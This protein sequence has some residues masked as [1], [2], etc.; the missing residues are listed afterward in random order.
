M[1]QLPDAP[2]LSAPDDRVMTATEPSES[3][4]IPIEAAEAYEAAFVPAFFAQWAPMLC[5]AAHIA[6]GHRIL[7][8]ACGTGIVART[9]ADR[10][11]TEGVV[12]VDLNEAM[13]TV[14]RRV[15]PQ[16]DWRQGDVAALP[17][18]DATF[19]AVLSQMALMFFPDRVGALREMSRVAASG[20][21]V[22]VLVPSSLSAQPAYGPFVDMAVAHAGPEARSLLSMYFACGDIDDL[23]ASFQRA[24]LEVESTA[25]R[26]GTARFPSVDALV[27]TE[28]ESTPLGERISAEVYDRI[29]EGAREVLDPFIMSGGTLE[30]P[31]E[32]NV[33]AA[34]RPSR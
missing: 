19:D 26:G 27:A 1:G 25:T 21:T 22:A 7:D 11:G 30:A 32:V 33:V 20:A 8:V 3:F 18:D 29:R 4:Q 28:V 17:F 23:T 6:A 15:R 9:A 34:R 31:F 13:L 24:G 14:A 16:L 5:E 2:R 12:G 10:V